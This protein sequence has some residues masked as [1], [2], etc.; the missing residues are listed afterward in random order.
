MSS[1]ILRYILKHMWLII[2]LPW[3]IVVYYYGAELCVDVKQ[4]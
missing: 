3:Y 2:N 4:S 1:R